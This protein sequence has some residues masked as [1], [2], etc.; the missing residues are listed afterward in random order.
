MLNS[1]L[2]IEILTYAC[3]YK[4]LVSGWHSVVLM[5]KTSYESVIFA[6]GWSS[7]NNDWIQLTCLEIIECGRNWYLFLSFQANKAPLRQLDPS[8]LP[9]MNCGPDFTPSF[10]NLGR[11]GMGG[12]GGGGGRGPVS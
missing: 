8:R 5:K 12:G 6:Y 2:K 4:D 9:G 11:P 3:V 10:A 7:K 1:I